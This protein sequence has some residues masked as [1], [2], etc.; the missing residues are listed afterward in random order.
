MPLETREFRTKPDSGELRR[1]RNA[2]DNERPF[3][4]RGERFALM[5]ELLITE[6]FGP[7]VSV[8]FRAFPKVTS[9]SEASALPSIP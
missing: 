6:E 1:L 2:I 4:F 8:R 3:T 5:K 7:L 9:S